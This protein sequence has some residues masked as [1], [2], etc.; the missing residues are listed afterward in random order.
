MILRCKRCGGP[1]SAWNPGKEEM[2]VGC[3]PCL[4]RLEVMESLLDKM[5][6]VVAAYGPKRVKES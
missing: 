1:L 5:G 2:K 6:D 4:N 3:E